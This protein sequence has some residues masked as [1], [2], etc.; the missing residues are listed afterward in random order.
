MIV[1]LA[2][3]AGACGIF[4]P[5]PLGEQLWRDRCAACHGVDGRGN[6]PR[7]MGKPYADLS[8]G[9]WRNDGDPDSVAEVVRSGVFGEMPA[10]P[11]L[12]AEEMAALLDWIYGLRGEV[13]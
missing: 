3:A 7:Y 1:P 5:R 13:P 4:A 6:T 9:L 10:N 2:F 11:D 8:D 12:T